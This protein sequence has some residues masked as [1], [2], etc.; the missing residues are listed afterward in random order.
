AAFVRRQLTAAARLCG[1]R[2]SRGQRLEEHRFYH[3]PGVLDRRLPRTRRGTAGLC[4]RCVPSIGTCMIRK[5]PMS[6]SIKTD[7][8]IACYRTAAAHSFEFFKR[9]TVLDDVYAK[10]LR[11]ADGAGFLLPVCDLHMDDGAL[12]A[13][14]TRWRNEDVGAYPSQFV[15]TPT[16][17]KAW[18]RD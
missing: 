1:R 14:L 7:R 11:L 16:S 8:S 12:I 4:N 13:D 17:T 10:S 5:W 15:A 3:E 6:I 9:T 2:T 18:L